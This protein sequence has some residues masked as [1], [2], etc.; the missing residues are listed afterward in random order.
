MRVLALALVLAATAAEAQCFLA[1]DEV[2]FGAE[3]VQRLRFDLG[4]PLPD[5]TKVVGL[6]EG[7]FQDRFIQARLSVEEKDLDTLLSALH[8]ERADLAASSEPYL[9]GNGPAWF[10]WEGREGLVVTEG[11]T[12]SLDHVTVAAAPDAEG[13]RRWV[14]YLWGFQT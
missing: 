4:G 13:P 9:G 5:G 8:V 11:W 1:C 14:V 7:G 6:L 2:H 12:G 10:D 3:A